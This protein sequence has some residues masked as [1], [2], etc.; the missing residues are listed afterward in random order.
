[1][2]RF[3]FLIAAILYF[4]GTAAQQVQVERFSKTPYV[5]NDFRD[6]KIKFAFGGKGTAKA[7]IF[8]RDASL[9]F[10][11]NDKK[12]KA[13]LLNVIEVAFGD[14]V[15]RKAGEQLGRVIAEKNGNYLVEI[16]TVDM[17]A[18]REAERRNENTS[19]LDLPEFNIFIETD[20]DYYGNTIE[21]KFP[22]KAVYYFLK[23]G[24][25]FKAS[26]SEFKKHLRKEKKKEFKEYFGWPLI[27]TKKFKPFNNVMQQQD[28]VN[29]TKFYRCTEKNKEVFRDP[30]LIFKQ[31][32][33]NGRFLS[34]VL[35]YDALFGN[36]FIGI[37]GEEN[38]LKYISIILYSKVFVYY[39]LMTSRRWL[40]ERDELNVGELLSFPLPEPS[41]GS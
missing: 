18:M 17:E 13:N 4:S 34:T 29:F 22:L 28:K 21:P 1:M 31:S 23:G 2:K 30:H 19:F 10:L 40:V 36:S 3:V 15:Y 33:K 7:N 32:P 9:I 8:L 6:A 37:H 38:I 24:V 11:K 27:T 20:G 16:T 26:E 41:T 5:F 14:T 25:P 39:S 35:R 12:M